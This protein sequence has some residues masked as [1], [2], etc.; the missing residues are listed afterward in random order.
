MEIDRR[1]PGLDGNGFFN[2]R[3]VSVVCFL[4]LAVWLSACQTASPGPL[5]TAEQENLSTP[6][7]AA[8]FPSSDDTPVPNGQTVDTP[9]ETPEIPSPSVLPFFTATP[10]PFGACTDGLAFLGDLTY[11][12]R[13]KVAPGQ[14]L[15]KRWKVRNSGQCDWGPEY[16]FRWI[17]GTKLAARDEFAL[18]PAV[19]GS[20]A[21]LVIPM[22]APTAAG[23]YTSNWSAVSPLGVPFGDQLYIDIIVAP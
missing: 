14:P 5:P 13:T 20:E 23:E 15:E 4:W 1:I 17:G 22:I 21:V 7:T 10:L 2:R 12:D 19:A 18:Y 16:R 8:A 3:Q 11:P 6:P 9:V